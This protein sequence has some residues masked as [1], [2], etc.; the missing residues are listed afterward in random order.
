MTK[1]V[2]K[3]LFR[4]IWECAKGQRG[5][6][7][8]I[9]FLFFLANLTLMFQPYFLGQFFNALQEGGN[10]VVSKSFL[11]MGLFTILSFIFWIFHGPA[12]VM[13]RRMSFYIS[14]NFYDKMFTIIT[15][16]P[17]KWHKDHHSGNTIDRVNRAGEAIKGLMDEAYVYMETIVRFI[18]SLVAIFLI[19]KIGGAMILG[20]GILVL[21]VIFR[22][23]R[24]LTA[25]LRELNKRGHKIMGVFFDYV[26]NITTIITLRLQSLAR[27]DYL[28]NFTKIYPIYRQNIVVN[29][30]KWCT[31]SMVMALALMV[32]ILYYVY[33]TYHN[34]EALLAG[35][36]I[37]LYGY[38]EKFIDV[39]FGLAWKYERLVMSATNMSSI[40]NITEAYKQFGNN[41]RFKPFIEAW[42]EIQIKG[43]YFKYE[44]KEHHVHQ[45][46]GI[47]LNLV[48]G[49]KIAFVGESGGGKST[50]MR[51]LR[52][53]HDTDKVKVKIDGKE[54]KNLSALSSMTSL[55]PQDPEIFENTI[56]YNITLGISA[57]NA[58]IMRDV[59]LACFDVVLKKL[60]NGLETNIREK[61]VNLS[62][63]EKQRLALARGIFASKLS[64]IVLL[65]EP[66]SSVDSTNERKIYENIMRVFKKKCIISSI[67]RLHLLPMFDYIY[68][69]K[70]GKIVEEG[71][72]EELVAAG[73]GFAEQWKQYIKR[74]KE[75]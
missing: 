58:E 56:K 54:F 73:G 11:Y 36:M 31:V 24:V 32:V 17:I 15:R 1:N 70:Q 7:V 10:E 19:M 49:K 29:E 55:I 64:S 62:G 8:F 2:Y 14:R 6:L 20:F 68:V 67:H 34:G 48:R 22:F 60:P 39:F 38:V 35:T 3:N 45:L 5:R 9:Y 27:K 30:V 57:T 71:T 42:R 41:K 69:L 63:G 18:A 61:G 47:N 46:S 13:E 12:R 37:M 40:D 51:L 72:F 16:L 50:L 44:D 43:L 23:D 26:S 53:L 52:G 4:M 21:F 65:D 33:E 74:E 66:T 25:S 75:V 59:K 28:K